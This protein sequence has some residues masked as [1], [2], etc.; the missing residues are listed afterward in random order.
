M[1][2]REY[3]DQGYGSNNVF[4]VVNQEDFDSILKLKKWYFQI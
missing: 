1:I 3:S 4:S 2:D